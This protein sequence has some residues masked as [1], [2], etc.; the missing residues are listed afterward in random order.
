MKNLYELIKETKFEDYFKRAIKDKFAP[1]LILSGLPP[2]ADL[3]EIDKYYSKLKIEPEYITEIEKRSKPGFQIEV[4][5][6]VNLQNEYQKILDKK[7]EIHEF[8]RRWYFVNLQRSSN[9]KFML[10]ELLSDLDQR[11]HEPAALLK[12]LFVG[13]ILNDDLMKLAE[14]WAYCDLF[15]EF[16]EMLQA[17]QA[18]NFQ[19]GFSTGKNL[20]LRN[21][22]DEL[23]SGG[24]IQS[25]YSNFQAA[26]TPLPLPVTFVRV[27]WIK[28]NH[29]G[30]NIA[31]KALIDLLHLMG[32]PADQIEDKNKIA[33]CFAD[34]E[35]QPL[36]FSASNYF[37]NKDFH[38]HSEFYRALQKIIA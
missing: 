18:G 13:N 24:F 37:N 36:Q 19:T 14:L 28:Q 2:D 9:V 32:V 12:N 38:Q 22:F 1:F 25:D 16:Y 4:F 23:S 20:N 21:I 15:T 29:R 8:T 5:K 7:S 33:G 6:P 27:R 35:G 34:A 30:R 17:Y 26:F 11:L 31:K 10:T 3:I